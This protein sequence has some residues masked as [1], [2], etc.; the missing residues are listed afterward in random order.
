MSRSVRWSVDGRGPRRPGQGRHQREDGQ[1]DRPRS[2]RDGRRP[3]RTCLLRA[4]RTLARRLLRH[5]HTVAPAGR[6]QR[7]RCHAP[8]HFALRQGLAGGHR[9]G[10]PDVGPGD[11]PDERRHRDPTGLPAVNRRAPQ[12]AGQGRA[13]QGRGGTRGSSQPAPRGTTRAGGSAEGRRALD[14]RARARREGPREDHPR[15]GRCHRSAARTQRARA[16]GG[17]RQ[18]T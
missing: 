1:G 15:P 2:P 5:T 10:D 13:A 16:H 7:A 14:R 3:D 9:E 11:Q 18:T 6:V 12:G 4:R 8:R 17:L